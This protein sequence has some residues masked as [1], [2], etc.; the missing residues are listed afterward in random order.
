MLTPRWLLYILRTPG[1]VIL[2]EPAMH[3]H[4]YYSF[5]LISIGLF[6]PELT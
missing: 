2:A 6:L 5:T 4:M 3:A 1:V